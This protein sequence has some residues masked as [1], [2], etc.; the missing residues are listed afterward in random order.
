LLE[1]GD[2]AALEEELNAIS[3][4]AEELRQPA[5]RWLVVVT[6][7]TLALFEGRFGEAE[8]LI[9]D[10]LALG[11][12]AQASDAL[13]SHRVQVFT[14][15]WQRGELEGLEELLR[16]SIDEYP[17][18]PMFR[19]MLARLYVAQDR[20]SDARTLLEELATERFA[21]L[22]LTNEW[23]FSVGF[24]A[25]VAGWLGDADRAGTLYEL[26]SPYAHRNACTADYISTG[27][28]SRPLGIAASTT[29]R[30]GDA[31][32]HFEDALAMNARMRARPW[33]ARTQ[34][35]YARMLVT[36]GGPEHRGHAC[37]LLASC[38]GTCRELG[39]DLCAT[40]AS[41]LQTLAS[42][43]SAAMPTDHAV[44]PFA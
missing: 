44:A 30:P 4:L 9:E 36:G 37:E 40:A 11:E 27:S 20:E 32:R 33:V 42:S 7:A 5:Q 8:E 25:D 34:L 39:M 12:S 2:A 19:C 41:R 29:G 23:L 6:R 10:A 15:G 28:V 43:S 21:A 3:P 14:L 31:A 17:A 24:L 13:L 26:L 1:L 38:L 35:D 18:R 16:R 22:P